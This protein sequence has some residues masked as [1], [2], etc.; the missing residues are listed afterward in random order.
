M[1]KKKINAKYQPPETS[2]S[3]TAHLVTK[4]VLSFVPGASDLFEYF[5]K[6]PLEKRLEK[7]REEV[8]Q[9][10][11]DLQENKGVKLDELRDNDLFI[12]II[13][14]ATTI[15][16]RSHQ[17]EKLEALKSAIT[18]SIISSSIEDDVQLSFIRFIDEL[19]PS[20]VN[21]LR[22]LIDNEEKIKAFTRGFRVILFIIM[23]FN[24]INPFIFLIR[25]TDDDW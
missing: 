23:F 11:I 14:Q 5:V 17:K 10:L 22:F 25:K 7:W 3:D 18:S 6:P 16:L 24:E 15:A 1:T 21:L 20:H 2:S 4:A 8:A 9:A 13:S 12:S 19:T